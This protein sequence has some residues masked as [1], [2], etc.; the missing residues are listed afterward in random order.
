MAAKK[1]KKDK[2][3]NIE[4]EVFEDAIANEVVEATQTEAP[5]P[6]KIAAT[7][8]KGAQHSKRYS[9]LAQKVEP[10]RKYLLREAVQLAKETAK[11][12]FLGSVEAHLTLNQKGLRGFIQLPHGIKSTRKT[13][14]FGTIDANDSIIVGDDASIKQIEDGSLVA[15]KDFH[16]VIATPLFMPKLAKVARILGPKGMMPN[17]KSGT[18]TDDPQKAVYEFGKGKVEYKTEQN[19]PQLHLKVGKTDFTNDQLTENMQSIVEA[20]GSNKIVAVT[21]NATMGPGIKVSL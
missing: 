20:I 16:A 3:K 10:N 1:T 15:G 6:K 2:T 14:V 5:A 4:P 18:V 8:T 9:E 21:I 19:N 11:T 17:P 12:N 7:K 13:L